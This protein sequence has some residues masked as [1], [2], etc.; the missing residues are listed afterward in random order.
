LFDLTQP[1]EG[2]TFKKEYLVCNK[3]QN[4]ECW[5]SLYNGK[6]QQALKLPH[7]LKRIQFYFSGKPNL[8]RG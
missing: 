6:R 1:L 8:A 2:N 7:P 3:E 4:S 5:I